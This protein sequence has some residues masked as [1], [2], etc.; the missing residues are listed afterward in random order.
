[1]MSDCDKDVLDL[2]ITRLL[3]GLH[4]KDRAA[5]RS[6]LN[7]LDDYMTQQE[8]RRNQTAIAA[9]KRPYRDKGDEAA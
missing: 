4:R 5:M 1:M 9:K 7:E 8:A 6:A 3:I 2:L